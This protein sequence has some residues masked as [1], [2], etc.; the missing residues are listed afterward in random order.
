MK[1][2]ISIALV[3]FLAAAQFT[4]AAHACPLDEVDLPVELSFV[5][6]DQTDDLLDER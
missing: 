5:A 6:F 1:R 4:W 3:M 2:L